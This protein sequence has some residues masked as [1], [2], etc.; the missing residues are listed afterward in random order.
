MSKILFTILISST[1]AYA[2]DAQTYCENLKKGA[3]FRIEKEEMELLSKGFNVE[4]SVKEKAG[5]DSRIVTITYRKKK[6][7]RKCEILIDD[8]KISE[9]RR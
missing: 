3:P 7:N 2:E 5:H 9:I 8:G 4:T 6:S 1:I